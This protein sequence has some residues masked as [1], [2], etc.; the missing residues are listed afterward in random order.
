MAPDGDRIRTYAEFWPYYVS[1][2]S[3]PL[4][5]ALHYLGTLAGLAIAAL[6]LFGASPLWL[7]VALVAGYGPAWV[8]HFFVEHNRP[9]T[10]QYPLWSLVS[11]FRMLGLVL[12]GRMG[13]ELQRVRGIRATATGPARQS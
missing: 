13:S 7:L 9:A 10:L 11:D 3:R 6:V 1:E 8:G 5:R 2:H 12:I 4:C